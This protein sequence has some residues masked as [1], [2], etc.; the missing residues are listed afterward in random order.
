[1]GGV[2]FLSNGFQIKEDHDDV[3]DTGDTYIYMAFAADPDTEQ[4]TLA[5]SFDIETYNMTG[6]SDYDLS[7]PFKP[8]FVVTKTRDEGAHWSWGDIVRGNN[9][10]LSS[11]DANAVSTSNQWR[12]KDWNAGATTVTIAQHASTNTS[13]ISYAFKADD[14]EP[15]IFGGPAIAVYKFED[16]ANDVTGDY[17]GTASNVSYV[18][19]KFNKAADF[20]GSSSFIDVSGVTLGDR[21]ISLWVKFDDVTVSYQTIYDTDQRASP[22]HSFGDWTLNYY[23]VND[24]AK[25]VQTWGKHDGSD[26]EY[27][28]FD[29]TA[30][31]DTWYHIVTVDAPNNH[32]LY[33]NGEKKT[34]TTIRDAGENRA[35]SSA[36]LTF[37][38]KENTGEA[39]NGQLDQIRIYRGAI[40]DVG[41]AELYAESTSQNNDLELGGP[42]EILVSANAN[43]GFSIVK[44]DGSGVSGTKIPHGLSAAPNMTI[45]K[46]TSDSST[47]WIVHHSSLGNSKYLTLNSDAVEDT[48]TNWLVPSATTFA[49]NQTFGN[50]NTSGRQYIAYCFHDIAGYQKLGSYTGATSGVTVNVGFKPD[51]IMI[52]SSSNVENWAILDTRRGSKKVI[53]PN[54]S[55]VE[56]DSSLNTFTISDTGFSFPEQSIADAMLNENGY[57]YIYWAVAK[58]VPS[59]T[60]LENSFKA[61]TYTGNGGTQS[62]TG[63]GFKPDLVWI[64]GRNF[65]DNHNIADTVR[66]ATKFVFPNLTSQEFTNSGYLTSFDSDGFSLGS[67]GSIN[68]NSNTFVS[69]SWKAGNNWESNTD[70]SINSLIN[71]NTGNGFS[72]VKWEGTGAQGTIGHGLNSAPEMIISKRLD[73]AN[74]WSVYHKDLSLSHSTYPNWLYLN[75][76]SSEQNSASS[77]NHPYYARPSATVI[78]QNTGT[79]ESTNV[80]GGD[81]I[82]YCWTSKSSFSKFGSYSGNGSTGQTI[83][84]G[85]QPDFVMIKSS[86]NGSDWYMIDSVRPNNKFLVADGNASEYT[87]SDTHTFVSTGF[88]LSGESFNNSGYDWIYIAFKM[89]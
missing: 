83:T 54:R 47:N 6:G 12:V 16:N 13:N 5:S 39:L 20:N 40:S 52:K 48:S 34:Y 1:M 84:T 46:C 29:F 77:A 19:G 63:V 59:N 71:A 45:I 25:L 68:G 85:F 64:K 33:I 72:I 36:E 9:S 21:S 17:N 79:S 74:N 30:S 89:N 2:D 82:S 55:N 7:F 86:N 87:A 81:Y 18:T 42:P 11:N 26:Y 80:S 78:Y 14:N 53:N 35:L 60:T 76:G 3:N 31:N 15:T 38:Q 62:I 51:F 70:G 37:G 10:N 69:W 50:A 32:A 58:N 73:S 28:T 27:G 67:D 43:A 66:G 57:E 56:G 8:Q 49:L 24:G 65:A 23:G 41:V 61:V 4:P 88:T 22:G 75:L 44:Y